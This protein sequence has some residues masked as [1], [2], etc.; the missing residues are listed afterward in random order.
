MGKDI[1]ALAIAA[2]NEATEPGTPA[3]E[4]RNPGLLTEGT[5]VREFNTIVDGLR[6]LMASIER[7]DKDASITVGVTRYC[8]RNVEKE[9]LVLDYLS[10]AT[11]KEVTRD[12]TI[13]AI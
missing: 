3:F 13:G 10:R 2:A 4:L 11:G 6:A 1:L 8:G 9:L 5:K 12:I 7:L